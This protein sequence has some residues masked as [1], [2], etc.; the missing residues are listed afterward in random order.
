MISVID[1]YNFLR[2]SRKYSHLEIIS[3][4]SF[5][6][7]TS[8]LP[9]R[10]EIVYDCWLPKTSNFIANGYVLHNSIEQD[11]DLVLMLYRQSYYAQESE[12]QSLTDIIIAKHRNGPIGSI[13][14][15]F[16]SETASFGNII[17]F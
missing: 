17:K 8:I 2:V 4:L 1:K 15:I 14:L 6:L 13:K 5:L 10:K 3:Y 11:A 12:D 7:A 9:G 16:D